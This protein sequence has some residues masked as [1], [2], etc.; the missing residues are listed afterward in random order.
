MMA[1]RYDIFVSYRRQGSFDTANLIADKLRHAGY[2]V[3]FD[4]DT[5]NA[6]K[7][8]VQLL[9]VIKNC[10]D[11]I[12]VLPEHA[13]DR[14]NDPEDW[15]RKEVVCALNNG[16]NII[17]VMLAG[18]EWPKPMPEG[19]E[20]LPN[21]QAIT[22]A[23]HDYFDMAVERLKGFLKSRPSLFAKHFLAVMVSACVILLGGLAISGFFASRMIDTI[24]T[25]V[26]TQLSSSMGTL[27]QLADISHDLETSVDKFFSK[28]PKADTETA[29]VL[30]DN[31][32]A[33]LERTEKEVARLYQ[34][35][36]E[37]EFRITSLQNAVLGFRSIDKEELEAFPV[38]Y[39]TMFEDVCDNIDA[40]RELVKEHEYGEMSE[41]AFRTRFHCFQYNLNAL[42]YAYMQQLS[43]FPKS[44]L[45][46]HHELSSKWRCYPNGTPLGLTDAE[47]ESFQQNEMTRMEDELKLLENSQNYEEAKMDEMERQLE[48]LDQRAQ[49][50]EKAIQNQ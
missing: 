44:C 31:L 22:S 27:D 26:A 39:G 19:L 4:V 36:P 13:L 46:T 45:K 3:F 28:V 12:L 16:K 15:I 21:Y 30:K 33:D 25:E 14:C 6:G 2:K 35:F 17:P 11:F 8:N 7:F 42:Y 24:C 9:E 48:L 20:E 37:P 49:A 23:G 41:K 10:K 18:F 40:L 43:H 34:K 32:M 50:I 5:L 47:Y 38:L 29:L 1:K